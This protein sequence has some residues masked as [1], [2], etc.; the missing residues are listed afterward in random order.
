VSWA[1]AVNDAGQVAGQADRQPGGYGYPVRWSANGV[2]TDLGGPILNR[3]GV[4]N[5][6]DPAGRVVGGQRPADS[7]GNPIA[8]LYDAAGNQTLLGNPPESL[9]AA[10]A[11]NARGQIVGSPAFVWQN[12]TL[13]HLPVLPWGGQL[14]GGRHRDQ[15]QRCGGRRRRRR[16][17]QRACTRRCGAAAC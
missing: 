2:L 12:G 15:H 4:G 9:N 7:E 14:V 6:I 13:T 5:G 17:R 1:N 8:I 16:G 11:I 3:L 10:T